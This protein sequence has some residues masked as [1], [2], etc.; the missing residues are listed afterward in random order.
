M[1]FVRSDALDALA[2][3][4]SD[5]LLLGCLDANYLQSSWRFAANATHTNVDDFRYWCQNRF[6]F[7]E[8]VEQYVGRKLNIDVCVIIKDNVPDTFYYTFVVCDPT[9]LY[10]LLSKTIKMKAFL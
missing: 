10:H 6:R 1:K 8:K 5:S 7:I 9:K 2:N 4:V 3:S